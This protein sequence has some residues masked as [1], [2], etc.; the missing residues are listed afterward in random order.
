MS[1]KVIEKTIKSLEISL[2]KYPENAKL[3]TSLAEVYLK[4]DMLG[5]RTL[6]LLEALSEKLPQ[7]HRIHRALSICY[8]VRQPTELAT[9][10]HNLEEIDTQAL[11]ETRKRL[12][13]LIS[14]H[15]QSADLHKA[16]GDIAFFLKRPEE[17]LPY[18]REAIKLGFNDFPSIIKSFTLAYR[19]Y[20]LPTSA[21]SFFAAIYEELEL[22]DKTADLYR[23]VIQVGTSDRQP[24]EWMI[25]YLE[26]IVAAEADL[27]VPPDHKVELVN[28]YIAGGKLPDA[29]RHARTIPMDELRD[30][31]IIKKIA[32]QLIDLE[33]YR[34]A[35]DFLSRV[36][37]DAE[38][39]VLINE[40]ALR[41]ER[42]GELDTAVYLLQFIN[43]HDL[44]IVEAKKREDMEL[45]LNTELGLAELH[46]KNQKWESALEKYVGILEMGYDDWESIVERIEELLKTIKSPQ[47]KYFDFLGDFFIKMSNHY[48]AA[49][50]LRDSLEHYPDEEQTQNKLR[51]LY[52]NL[53]AMDPRQPELRLRSGDLYL[54]MGKTEKAISEFEFASESPELSIAASKRLIQTYKTTGDFSLALEKYLALEDLGS[55]DFED[56]FDLYEK[57]AERGLFREAAD[58]LRIINEENP[59]YK[60]VA[61]LLGEVDAKAKEQGQSL[62][63]DPKMRELIGDHAIGRYKYI[64]K[65]GSG[66]MGVVH[67]VFDLKNNCVVAMKILREG[68]SGSSKAIDRFFREARI[69]ATLNHKNIVKIYDY[70]ISNVYGQSFITMSFVQGESLRDIIERRFSDSLDITDEDI[71]QSLYYISQLCEAL[72]CT[73]DHGIIH[74]DIKPDN[75]MIERDDLVKITDF[76]IIHVEE[77]SFTPTGALI[78]TPRYMS[79]EQ[80]RGGKIDCRSDIYASGIIMYELLVGSP[81]FISGDIAFQQVNIDP[82]PPQEICPTVTGKVNEIIMKCLKKNPDDR[83]QTA[84][85]MKKDIDI[86]LEE[87]G[88]Y[89]PR[90]KEETPPPPGKKKDHSDTLDSDIDI[91]MTN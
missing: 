24:L 56:L 38:N 3:M 60:D 72:E 43:E 19:S 10:L 50:I 51:D 83:Y 76:G 8:L 81:P 67:K 73:H 65:V 61:S 36:P 91:D 9:N 1:N 17:A 4:N 53:L 35:F 25:R 74:R 77:A 14:Q 70:N 27:D 26:E 89:E 49:D 21:L 47:W 69:A 87:L 79:P 28:Y 16:L 23:K 90:Q 34:Q 48:K 29:I 54:K 71:V 62:F 5:P 85:E 31:T 63:I 86:S 88:G 41:L 39:K 58:A 75:I 20:T 45:K 7:N 64:S 22:P 12:E 6:E 84:P 13:A 82:T 68:L 80:V 32:R 55:E 18:Y 52:D 2:A 15:S 33:D 42:H 40:I 66:G 30:Y 44:V 37:L 78:G 46:Y 57:L 59:E 11:T